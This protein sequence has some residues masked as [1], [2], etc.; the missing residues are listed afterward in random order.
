[1]GT[2][3]DMTAL[4]RSIPHIWMIS[5]FL[6]HVR[7]TWNL[8]ERGVTV[9]FLATVAMS[10]PA[11]CILLLTYHLYFANKKRAVSID[12]ASLAGAAMVAIISAMNVDRLIAGTVDLAALFRFATE[13]IWSI[14]VVIVFFA[15]AYVPGKRLTDILTGNALGIGRSLTLSLA[16]GTGIWGYT[17]LILDLTGLAYPV[18]AWLL[19]IAAIAVDRKELGRLIRSIASLPISFPEKMRPEGVALSLVITLSLIAFVHSYSGL[20]AGGWDTFHQYL[21][22]PSVYEQRHGLTDF[23]FHPHWGFPQLSEMI[24]QAGLLFGNERTAFLLNHCLIAL[25]L[26]GFATE[27][28]KIAGRHFVWPLGILASV[29]LLLRFESGYL[30]AE[31][32]L[33]LFIIALLSAF[34]FMAEKRPHGYRPWILVGIMLGL[35]L[36]VKYTSLVFL[37]GTVGTVYIFRKT[38]L[39]NR[40]KA[41][42]S[43][44]VCLL[45]FSPWLAKNAIRYGNPLHPILP[46]SDEVSERLGKS[47]HPYF[48]ENSRED[49]FVTKHRELFSAEIPF[50]SRIR[51]GILPFL[52]GDGF[53]ITASGPFF[54][55]FLPI[56]MISFLRIREPYHRFLLL[57]STSGF[58]LGLCSFSGQTWYLLPAMPPFTLALAYAWKRRATTRIP[59]TANV[60]VL[61][62]LFFTVSMNLFSQGALESVRY[63][64]S[65]ITLEEQ[66]RISGKMCGNHRKY[67]LYRI[68]KDINTLIREHPDT[69]VVVYGFM[70]TQGFFIDRSDRHFIPDFFG[71]LFTCMSENGNVTEGM[72]KLNVSHILF[73][74]DPPSGC[75]P[76][77]HFAT[78]RSFFLFRDFVASHGTLIRE[79]GSFGL[80]SLD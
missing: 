11:A 9:S 77:D 66:L 79:E 57:L 36:S 24:F 33:F 3:P 48:I 50:A 64:R 15:S 19:A 58:V 60:L 51:L 8:V 13:F 47:C 68:W 22:F 28:R 21:T 46:G 12:A 74:S 37:V 41:I 75:E 43:L 44:L 2:K 34:G 69:D 18:A 30:K 40:K 49:I 14:L 73:E 26:L 80:Y 17:V 70:D 71:S 53:D 7:N 63:A 67:H 45:V 72:R 39:L 5:F 65:E 52:N 61:L 16:L 62:W 23:P 76:D 25:G 78:C 56:L 54:I 31:S 1:M 59:D 4:I 55:V 42:L 35:L 29:P 32:V 6:I 27:A 10:V 38:F 20:A